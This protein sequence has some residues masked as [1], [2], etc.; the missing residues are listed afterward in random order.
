MTLYLA[1][2]SNLCPI[3]MQQRCPDSCYMGNA[4][5]HGWKLSFTEIGAANVKESSSSSVFFAVYKL[6]E[7][8]VSALDFHESIDIGTYK[9]ETI[10]V[11]EKPHLIYVASS[12]EVGKPYTDYKDRILSG[13]ISRNAPTTYIKELQDISHH[14]E[15]HPTRDYSDKG[16]GFPL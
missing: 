7:K 1:Y 15:N 11:N 16:G 10:T 3:Q 4:Q 12:Q 8:C 14:Q 5:I 9:K 2:G 6:T 13:M